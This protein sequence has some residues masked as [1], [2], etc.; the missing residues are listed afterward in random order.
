MYIYIVI[1]I[2]TL[3]Y[4]QN[5]FHIEDRFRSIV[6]YEYK[7]WR[8]NTWS[9][10]RC[11]VLT[12]GFLRLVAGRQ[13]G[14][15]ATLLPS[16]SPSRRATYTTLTARLHVYIYMYMCVCGVYIHMVMFRGRTAG[17]PL[18]NGPSSPF[19]STY[20]FVGGGVWCTRTIKLKRF[21]CIERREPRK[22][23]ILHHSSYN[24]QKSKIEMCD[25]ILVAMELSRYLIIIYI[26]LHYSQYFKN[27][28]IIRNYKIC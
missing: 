1:L 13:A 14:T 23:R 12:F 7:K 5:P 17:K 25:G 19:L 9:T 10:Q 8:S 18:P 11:S 26:C 21:E 3:E 22:S 28:K 2:L 6:S 15:S 20:Y 4:F 27:Y 24:A 16:C